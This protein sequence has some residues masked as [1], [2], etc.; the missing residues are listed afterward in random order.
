[1]TSS[2]VSWTQSPKL[3]LQGEADFKADAA[4]PRPSLERTGW[5][6]E[7]K[8]KPTWTD[9]VRLESEPIVAKCPAATSIVTQKVLGEPR[10]EHRFGM[11]ASQT[12]LCLAEFLSYPSCDISPTRRLLGHQMPMRHRPLNTHHG[13]RP[14]IRDE[15]LRA[16]QLA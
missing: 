1:V 13:R 5:W 15:R 4:N 10:A 16:G 8:H 12:R 9:I 7:H 2:T 3:A 11:V 6:L 14:T